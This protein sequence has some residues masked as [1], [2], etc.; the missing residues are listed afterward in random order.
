[1]R[2]L[3]ANARPTAHARH[4]SPLTWVDAR[5]AGRLTVLDGVRGLA[6]ALVLLKHGLPDTFVPG[7]GIVGVDLFFV[8]SGFVITGTLL[9]RAQHN[10]GIRLAGFYGRRAVRLLPA[11]YVMLA[12]YVAGSV[13]LHQNVGAAIGAAVASVLYYYNFAAAAG[14]ELGNGPLWTLAT[15]EQFYF[16][17]PAIIGLTFTLKA[18]RSAV[19]LGSAATLIV[20]SW[21]LRAITWNTLGDAVYT[22]PSTWTDS[23][24]L[25]ATLALVQVHWP[26]AWERVGQLLG[27]GIAQTTLWVVIIGSAFIPH[28]KSEGWVYVWWLAP[29]GLAM[30]AALWGLIVRPPSVARA[31]LT[32]P[33][34]LFLGAVSYS[35][36]LYNFLVFQAL[37]DRLSNWVI[38][39]LLGLAVSIA[40]GALSRRFVELPPLRWLHRRT[41]H[42][43]LVP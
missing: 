13:V 23:L 31:A 3:A 12:A 6:I 17:W 4:L 29:L 26:S 41:T 1:M 30:A 42:P 19:L 32:A 2:T 16:I 24:L 18:R 40:L 21:V 27:H 5:S 28:M 9:R 43:P 10:D 34:A 7:G 39:F 22:L 33:P 36:Y 14:V 8:L 25:G 37:Q 38:I 20:T 15:E 11:L 35:T